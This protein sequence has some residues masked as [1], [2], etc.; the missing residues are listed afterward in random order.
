M[1]FISSAAAAREAKLCDARW[2]CAHGHTLEPSLFILTSERDEA[3]MGG[4]RQAHG[5]RDR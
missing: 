5:D 4:L 2:L 3:A 1:G